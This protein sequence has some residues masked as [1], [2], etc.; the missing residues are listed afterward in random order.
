[1][2]LLQPPHTAAVASASPRVNVRQATQHDTYPAI[3]ALLL[4]EPHNPGAHGLAPFARQF[5]FA[6]IQLAPELLPYSLI[7]F[8]HAGAWWAY[9]P[10]PQGRGPMSPP[11]L[12]P[13]YF[14]SR[15]SSPFL[16]SNLAMAFPPPPP[17]FS[18]RVSWRL[19][20]LVPLV[21]ASL[22][23]P[24]PTSILSYRSSAP[25]EP[26]SHPLLLVDGDAERR[27]VLL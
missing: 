22:H 23:I 8:D 15:L 24:T 7:N 20:V 9:P 6:A 12:G 16:L 2:L 14:S 11:P 10:P 4:F 18:R 25:V 26:A 1:M 17:P 3:S 5:F 21:R 13:P 27:Q 19:P